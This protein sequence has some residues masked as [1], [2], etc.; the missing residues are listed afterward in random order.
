MYNISVRR[1]TESDYGLVAK[2]GKVLEFNTEEEARQWGRE[3]IEGK[4]MWI[5]SW[6]VSKAV[7]ITEIEK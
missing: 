4:S 6:Y 1:A 5:V 3:N 7:L 2:G